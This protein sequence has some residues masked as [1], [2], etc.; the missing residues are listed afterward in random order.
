MKEIIGKI[1]IAA[2]STLRSA[3]E[4]IDRG[5]L[6]A[7]LVV[8]P[9]SGRFR[10]VL[11][12]GDVRRALLRGCVFSDRLERAIP[13][14]ASVTARVDTPFN[15]VLELFSPSIRI[16]P[17]LDADDRVVDIALFD[18]RRFFPV[19]EPDVGE[20]EWQYVSECILS[21][22]I[23][24][25]GSFV[26]R[27]EKAFADFC[28]V[29]HAISTS[30]GTTALHLALLACGIGPGDEVIVPT[31]S[32]IAT[33]NAVVYTGA[34]PVFADSDPVTWN[35]DP[36][37]IEPLVTRR[38][39]AIIA[40]HLYGHPA[41][42][43]AL[44]DIASRHDLLVIEDAAEA[45]GA[46]CRGRRV[47]SMGDLAIFSFFGNKIVTT[48]EGGMVV[49]DNARFA[50]QV[51]L[52]RDHGMDPDRRYW[53]TTLG[54]NYRLTN[55]QAAVGLA[56]ME[57]IDTILL[58]KRQNARAYAEVLREV[59]GIRLPPE[60]EW[61]ENVYWLYS[62]LV[63]EQ[64]F[65]MSRDMLMERLREQGIETRPFFHPIHRQPV[66]GLPGRL[67]V[68]EHLAA[69]GLSLPSSSRLSTG[70]INDIACRIR[71]VRH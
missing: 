55:M 26:P 21:G 67:E 51:R 64:V 47:G 46:L 23:S 41:D 48:G 68:A 5:G 10:A 22:W 57:K 13:P 32:F 29:E 69:H 28:G 34:T 2:G 56:Q 54:F 49:T 36:A 43:D 17:I 50:E 9:G 6:G 44:L 11:T 66:Y 37:G 4:V 15:K 31:L 71:G 65:G 12:D 42:M 35:I 19:A 33:A 38:T 20:K 60:E 39:R 14:G 24:S 18:K 61:A 63:D 62:I 3:L 1:C 25:T 27:F 52:L 53:H 45:H 59:P 30:S 58:R 8:E 16:V 40:V 70:E 7:A